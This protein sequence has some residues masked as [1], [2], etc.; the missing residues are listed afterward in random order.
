MQVSVIAQEYL[1]LAVFLFHHRWRCALDCEIMGVNED[2][3]HLVS[4]Q[5]KLK[6]HYRDHD[7][8]PKINKSDMAGTMEVIKEYPRLHHDVVRASLANVIQKAVIV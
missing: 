1:K 3:L 7:V 2:T 5:K 4:G 6:Y 8:L